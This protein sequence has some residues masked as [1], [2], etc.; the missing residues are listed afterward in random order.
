MVPNQQSHGR[1]LPKTFSLMNEMNERKFYYNNE[2]QQNNRLFDES[3]HF[4]ASVFG[5]IS[6]HAM[7]TMALRY[8]SYTVYLLFFVLRDLHE[9]AA[10]EFHFTDIQVRIVRPRCYRTIEDGSTQEQEPVT[11]AAGYS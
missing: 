9:L 3:G 2:V 1:V 5:S 8:I 11:K 10:A 7:S 6:L 4:T